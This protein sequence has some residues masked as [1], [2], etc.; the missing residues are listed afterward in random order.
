MTEREPE[1]RDARLEVIL[2]VLHHRLAARARTR[3][4]SPRSQHRGQGRRGSLVAPAGAR[5]DLRPL[6][7]RGFAPPIAEPM[8]ETLLPQRARKHVSTARISSG[9]RGSV[10]RRT[11]TLAFCQSEVHDDE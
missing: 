7:L 3:P 1:V 9:A 11:R 8:D 10:V 2:E 5:G 4:R 6:A